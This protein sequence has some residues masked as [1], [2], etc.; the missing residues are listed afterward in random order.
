VTPEISPID[1]ILDQLKIIQDTNRMIEI[2][3]EM[4]SSLMVRQYEHLKK[5]LTKNLFEMLEKSYQITIPI[6]SK[7]E[8]A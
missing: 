4:S 7:K 1:V 2:S 8:A 3:K 5:E 6:V